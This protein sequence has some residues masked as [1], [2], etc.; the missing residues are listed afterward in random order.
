[1][2]HHQ[3]RTLTGWAFRF[4]PGLFICA[5]LTFARPSDGL[6]VGLVIYLLTLAGFAAFVACDRRVNFALRTPGSVAFATQN[7]P[8]A[9]VH[10]ERFL[11]ESVRFPTRG[12]FTIVA[13]ANGVSYV[14]AG[15]N[16]V[17]FVRIPWSEISD[18]QELAGELCITLVDG[19]LLLHIPGGLLPVSVGRVRALAAQMAALQ[20][21]RQP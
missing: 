10:V 13:D 2:R 19:S 18:V 1:M 17:A 16:P 20:H 12:S 11:V 3:W 7:V 9:I 4:A 14:T 21:E 8:A 15:D 6:V 5:I